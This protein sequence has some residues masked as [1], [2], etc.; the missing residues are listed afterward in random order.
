MSKAK[1]IVWAY[2]IKNGNI[3]SGEW[4]YYGSRFEPVD[5]KVWDCNK[6]AK[7]KLLKDIKTIG[8]DWG[9][10]DF[11]VADT[12]S[13]FNGTFASQDSYTETLMG[14]LY[15]LDGSC[16]FVGCEDQAKM[17]GYIEYVSK[18]EELTKSMEEVFGKCRPRP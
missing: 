3:T 5:E 9:R 4:S 11:P 18:E 10:T 17:S 14:A 16:C 8:V 2:L 6:V 12:K 1:K 15:L 7:E 13:V